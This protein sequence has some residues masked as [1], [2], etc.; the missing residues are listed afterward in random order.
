MSRTNLDERQLQKRHKAGNQAFLLMAFLLLADMGLQNYGM[1]WL[2]YPLSNYT[3]FM[4]G[5]GSYLVRLIWSGAYVGPDGRQSGIGG[6]SIAG[7]VLAI[8][9]AA[10]ILIVTFVNPTAQ[11]AA[12]GGANGTVILIISV[13]AGLVILSTVYL[14]RRRNNRAE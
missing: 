3:I 8:V 9:V 10:C 13:T 5:V 11:S 6:K 12:N 1:K 2:E 14:I 7:A 4:L